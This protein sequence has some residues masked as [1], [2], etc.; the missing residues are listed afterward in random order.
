MHRSRKAFFAFRRTKPLSSP[1]GEFSLKFDSLFQ[2]KGIFFFHVEYRLNISLLFFVSGVAFMKK[3]INQAEQSGLHIHDD[4]PIMKEDFSNKIQEPKTVDVFRH[5]ID[6]I[7]IFNLEGELIDVNPAFC[8]IMEKEKIVLIGKKIDELVPVE[9]H[10]KLNRQNMLLQENGIAKG[11]LPF[12]S[13]KGITYFESVTTF[14]PETTYYISILRD[15]T[16]QRLLD[17]HSGRKNNFIKELFLEALDGIILFDPKGNILTANASACT[18]FESSHHHLIGQNFR[19]ILSIDRK[20]FKSIMAEFRKTGAVKSKIFLELFN[21]TKKHIEFTCKTHSYDG[22]IITIFR[23]I[24]E[25]YQMEK[26][27]QESEQKFR[28]IF[29]DSIDGLML[30][31]DEFKIVDINS[32]AEGMFGLSKDK[33]VGRFI[34]DIFAFQKGKKQEVLDH[35]G[36][37]IQKGKHNGSITFET[38]NGQK[39]HFDYSSK[40]RIFDGMN[41]TVLQDVSEKVEMQDQLRKSDTL[42]VLGELAAGIAHEIRNPMTALKGFIQLLEDSIKPEHSMYYQV[43]TSELAR[44]DSIINEFLIL[45]KPQAI[46]YQENNVNQIIKETV[47]L[48][49]AQAVLYNVQFN[50]HYSNDIPLLY[51]EPNQ[52]KKV[53]INIIKNAIE[54]M[55]SGGNIFITT[56]CTKENL[57]HIAIKDEGFGISKE[58]I[59]KLGEPFY[60]TKERGTGLGL[61]VSYKII[62]EHHGSIEI[63]SEEGKGTVFHIYLPLDLKNRT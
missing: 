26:D 61:M 49:N 18:I 24:S 60:T 42:N 17:E 54:V 50:T 52:L 19:R 27:L 41:L 2:E 31:N 44:I 59:K 46:R 62:E 29:E 45:A 14:D 38:K 58:K 4:A 6:A 12:K 47:K 34:T 39:R 11:I 9:K 7:I 33:L 16:P 37:V 22:Y 5:S 53:F 36:N 28:R 1:I 20:K 23:D 3:Q 43:I 51:C 25:S 8:S 15:K 55:P 10:Y 32:A 48:L 56:N 35:M 40:H 63:D 57:I 21:G 13:P 30:W